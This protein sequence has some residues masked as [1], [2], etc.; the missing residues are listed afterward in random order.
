M[1]WQCDGDNDCGDFSD[2]LNCPTNKSCLPYQMRCNNGVC[3]S[4]SVI[5]DT[6]NDCIDGSDETEELCGKLCMTSAVS[7]NCNDA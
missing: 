5:C 6:E 7:Y 4:R 2:E 1:R 3:V